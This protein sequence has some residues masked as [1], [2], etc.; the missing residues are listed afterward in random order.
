MSQIYGLEIPKWGMTMDE[1]AVVEWLVEEGAEVPE[2]TAVV[3]IESSKISGDL[4]S[5]GP[6]VLRRRLVSVGE[7]EPVGTLIGVVAAADVS[8]ADIDAFINDASAGGDTELDDTPAEPSKPTKPAPEGGSKTPAPAAAPVAQTSKTVEAPEPDQRSDRIPDEL[9]GTDD[10]EVPAT[11][12]AARL[13]QR[14]GIALSRIEPTGRG[15]RVSVRDIQDAV[16]AAGGHVGFGNDLPRVGQLKATGDDSAVPA[17]PIAR[18]LAGEH[19]VNLTQIRPSGR[20]GRVTRDDVLGYLGRQGGLAQPAATPAADEAPAAE[21]NRGTSA[22]LSAMRRVIA[23]RLQQSYQDSPHFRVTAHARIDALLAI[24]KEVNEHR[25][26]ARLTV[27]DLVVAATAQALLKVPEVNSQYDPA[28][29]TVTT[30]EH[31]DLSVAVSTDEGLITPIVRRADTKK[32]TAI[33][34][35]LTDL[36]TRAKAGT[37]AP[38]E[39]QGGTFTVSNLGMFQISSFDAIINP[40]QVAILAVA[41]GRQEFVPD[42]SGTPVLRTVLPV[43]LSAD[44]RVID[45]AVAARFCRELTRILESPSLIFA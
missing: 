25:D 15:G 33:S 11:P 40:P 32:V 21:A 6:G 27:N 36:A 24:R 17:T 26:D 3:T 2:G 29:E 44:H 39:F 38:D 37:L 34:A 41:A 10:E 9:K 4:E 31:V 42:E 1:G 28:S 45:G 12:H 22:P 20:A 7:V 8:D 30:F 19:G 14:V 18:R 5:E 23:S 16:A 43:T 13:A 35:E